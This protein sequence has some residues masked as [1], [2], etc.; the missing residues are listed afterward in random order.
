MVGTPLAKSLGLR[1][2]LLSDLVQRPRDDAAVGPL[3]RQPD[4]PTR[5][6]IQPE[7]LALIPVTRE[8]HLPAARFR[9]QAGLG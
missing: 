5:I 8:P 7:W 4:Q 6:V 9:L 3:V 2:L 1:E